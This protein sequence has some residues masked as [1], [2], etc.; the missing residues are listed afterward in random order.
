MA[1]FN[2][3][4]GVGHPPNEMIPIIPSRAAELRFIV[5]HG[6]QIKF[7][8]NLPAKAIKGAPKKGPGWHCISSD[9]PPCIHFI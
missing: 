3:A 7:S 8:R 5:P 6:F 1:D 2:S 9:G 4:A